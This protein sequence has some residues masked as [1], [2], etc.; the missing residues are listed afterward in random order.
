MCSLYVTF[1]H[2][3]ILLR[4]T[5][6]LQAYKYFIFE[7]Y[8]NRMQACSECMCEYPAKTKTA[9]WKREK[10]CGCLRKCCYIVLLCACVALLGISRWNFHSNKLCI[11]CK[12]CELWGY[13]VPLC[14]CVLLPIVLLYQWSWFLRVFF[15]FSC[16]SGSFIVTEKLH[17]C[18]VNPFTAEVAIMRLLGSAPKSHLCNQRRR[19]KVTGLSNL[20]TLL[21]T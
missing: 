5:T 9:E 19:S 21:L 17:C 2:V 11:S 7:G 4:G 3:N 10:V 13:F 16:Y 18:R 15:F 14:M 6:M 12:N 8:N 20:M 1:V